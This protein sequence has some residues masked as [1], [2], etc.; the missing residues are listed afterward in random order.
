MQAHPIR[1]TLHDESGGYAITPERVPLAVLRDFA[2]DVDDF[3]KGDGRQFDTGAMDVA[4]V[5]GSL[6]IETAPTAHPP[7]IQDLLKLA[8]DELID[9]LNNRRKEVVARWQKLAKS[10][11]KIRVEISSLALRQSIVINAQ[12]DYRA[13]DADQWVHVERYL[14]GEIVDL[15]GKNS[16]NAHVVLPDGKTLLVEA[17][18][19][20]IRAEKINRLYKTAMVRIRAEYNVL[21]REYRNA[22]LIEFAD[23]DNKLDSQALSRLTERGTKAWRDVANASAW[24][25]DLR[26]GNT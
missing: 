26:G 25:D 20:V 10:A 17:H 23:Y 6:G 4:V 14:R 13:D 21:T 7:L 8:S 16:A 9:S 12:S 15:G 24:V 1:I 11:R 5:K 19:D 18:K 3:L 22:Q 2:R